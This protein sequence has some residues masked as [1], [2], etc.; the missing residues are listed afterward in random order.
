MEARIDT[1]GDE[2]D[3][4]SGLGC[5]IGRLIVLL[6]GDADQAVYQFAM[7]TLVNLAPAAFRQLTATMCTTADDR[8]HLRAIEVLGLACKSHFEPN[9][10][11]AAVCRTEAAHDLLVSPIPRRLRRPPGVMRGGGMSR[12]TSPADHHR[13]QQSNPASP[14]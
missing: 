6:A 10:I 12:G 14:R 9:A 5:E 11:L 13:N 7:F 2:G 3:G 1:G 4:G 8:L